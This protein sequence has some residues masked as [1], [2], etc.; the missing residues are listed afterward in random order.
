MRWRGA[1]GTATAKRQ[2]Q[3]AAWID[4]HDDASSAIS[5]GVDHL[6]P[7]AVSRLAL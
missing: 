1:D 5:G 4:L 6:F 3:A 7:I 2:W